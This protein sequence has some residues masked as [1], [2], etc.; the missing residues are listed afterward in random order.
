MSAEKQLAPFMANGV[1]KYT[2]NPEHP[3]GV[4]REPLR[5]LEEIGE[6]L[7]LSYATL[8]ARIQA[9]RSGAAPSP[10]MEALSLGRHLYR[11]SEVKA[12]IHKNFPEKLQ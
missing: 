3:K 12:Y 7:G 9:N 6:R 1:F 4:R 2:I 8:K 11:F 10:A 5:N